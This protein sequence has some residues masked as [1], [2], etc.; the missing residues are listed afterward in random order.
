MKT[1]FTLAISL[2]MLTYAW[3][4]VRT[5]SNAPNV[6]QFTTIQLAIDASADG[7]TVYVY[8]SPNPYA[9]FPSWIKKLPSSSLAGHQTKIFLTSYC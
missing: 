6:A 8:G 3:A 7:D 1:I 9:G 5:V 4:T 2:C